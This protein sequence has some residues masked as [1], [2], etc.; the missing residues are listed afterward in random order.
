MP[1]KIIVSTI[2]VHEEKR[3]KSTCRTKQDKDFLSFSLLHVHP[4]YYLANTS[5]QVVAGTNALVF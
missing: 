3:E 4:L 1:D 2:G 5:P